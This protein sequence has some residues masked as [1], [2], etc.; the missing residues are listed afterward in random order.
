MTSKEFLKSLRSC[1][2]RAISNGVYCILPGQT[3]LQEVLHEYA[4]QYGKP[5]IAMDN[6]SRMWLSVG[7]SYEKY[8]CKIS[9]QCSY[10]K[11]EGEDPHTHPFLG[12]NVIFWYMT[13]A[14]NKYCDNNI[15]QDKPYLQHAFAIWLAFA[16]I[17]AS[18]EIL[19][20]IYPDE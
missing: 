11:V 4:L 12:N 14:L 15:I 7:P 6:Y 16:N 1:Y 18:I 8:L 20:G 9:A 2:K 17:V 3:G 19:L 13:D 10:P 5:F